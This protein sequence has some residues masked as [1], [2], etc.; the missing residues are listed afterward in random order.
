MADKTLDTLALVLSEASDIYYRTKAMDFAAEQARTQQTN[1]EI[2][3]QLGEER[4]EKELAVKVL[5]SQLTKANK[6]LAIVTGEYDSA[7]KGYQALT[8]EMYKLPESNRTSE[9]AAI[10]GDMERGSLDLLKQEYDDTSNFINRMEQG[11]NEL[12][13]RISDISSMSDYLKGGG[14]G[15]TGGEDAGRYD[16]GDFT[17]EGY[18]KDRGVDLEKKPWLKQSFESVTATPKEISALNKAMGL[19]AKSIIDVE[20]KQ[21]LIDA[22]NEANDA[23]KKRFLGQATDKAYKAIYTNVAANTLNPLSDLLKQAT[24][25][26]GYS[27]EERI[28]Q[29]AAYELDVVDLQRK[30]DALAANFD[31]LRYNTILKTVQSQGLSL[32]IIRQYNKTGEIPKGLAPLQQK[33]LTSIDKKTGRAYSTSIQ[34]ALETI[35]VEGFNAVQSLKG[36]SGITG[37]GLDLMAL[38]KKRASDYNTLI[39]EGKISEAQE[40]ASAFEQV[41]SIDVSSQEA[42]NDFQQKVD[43]EGFVTVK[44]SSLT[45][46][47]T[48]DKDPDK[49]FKLTT[50][51]ILL[52]NAHDSGNKQLTESLVGPIIAKYGRA[53]VISSIKEWSNE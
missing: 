27:D 19:D 11:K 32:D 49:P 31:P 35:Y 10:I 26:S 16:P 1:V 14:S 12:L 28:S 18:G 4:F 44:D 41:T 8:G 50:D 43:N 33:I 51:Y 17:L 15:F 9:S 30:K 2:D 13:G 29:S 46:I 53:E 52:K 45:E 37:T 34:Q 7:Q 20:Y 3:R 5:D 21:K 47:I 38:A 22:S 25:V 42:I 48:P 23:T 39:K 24:V 36:A 40:M 6:R